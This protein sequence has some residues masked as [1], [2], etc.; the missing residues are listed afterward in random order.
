MGTGITGVRHYTWKE[1][2]IL[3]IG[4]RQGQN[5]M[6]ARPKIRNSG[7]HSQITACLDAQNKRKPEEDTR[8]QWQEKFWGVGYSV[9]EQRTDGVYRHAMMS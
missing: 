2:F 5:N 1:F 7:L 8:G 6:Q 4:L 9:K 3:F